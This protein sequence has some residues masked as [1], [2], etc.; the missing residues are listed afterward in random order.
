MKIAIFGAG[1][2]GS[3]YGGYLSKKH[4]VWMIDVFGLYWNVD[5]NAGIRFH[6]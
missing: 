1:A 4:E 2:M 6:F 5:F 3:L